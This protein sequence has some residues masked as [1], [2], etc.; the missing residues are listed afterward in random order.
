MPLFIQ[1]TITILF[2]LSASA[3]DDLSSIQ[4]AFDMHVH[5]APDS[6]PRRVDDRAMA[7]LACEAGLAGFVIKSHAFETATRARLLRSQSCVEVFGGIVLNASVGGINPAAVEAMVKISGNRGRIVWLPTRDSADIALFQRDEVPVPALVEVL[8][9]IAA[10]DLILATGHVGG[11][12]LRWVIDLAERHQVSRI[13]IT[14]ALS[15]SVALKHDDIRYAIDRNAKLELVVLATL[16]EP[17]LIARYAE[18]IRHFGAKH[19]VLASDLGQPGNPLPTSGL[20]SLAR[21]L[22][23]HGLTVD[24]LNAMLVQ[25]PAWL[26]RDGATP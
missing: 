13:L 10:H 7:S 14:H 18:E 25:N 6:V 24:E 12:Q 1:G 8:Q 16:N 21:S 19:F 11:R 9:L 17:G 2:L 15:E 26:L 22:L 5:T 23:E 3:A 4:H 20:A